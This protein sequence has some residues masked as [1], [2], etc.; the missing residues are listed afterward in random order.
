ML[1]I[2]PKTLEGGTVHGVLCCWGSLQPG[3]MGSRTCSLSQP[4]D[5]SGHLPALPTQQDRLLGKGCSGLLKTQK[6]MTHESNL[7]QEATL[8]SQN[9]VGGDAGNVCQLKLKELQNSV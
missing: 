1:G 4:E 8:W 9:R 2:C 3:E 6:A 5:S 7:L